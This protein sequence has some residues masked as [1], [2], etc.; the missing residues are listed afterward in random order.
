MSEPIPLGHQIAAHTLFGWCS[1]CPGRSA[2]DEANAWRTW[3]VGN[4]PEVRD[5]IDVHNG[6]HSGST[7]MRDVP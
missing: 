3:A 7:R 1:A 4:L 5:A 6:P 2:V